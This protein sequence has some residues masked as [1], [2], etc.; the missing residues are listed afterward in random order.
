MLFLALKY[1]YPRLFALMG[2]HRSLYLFLYGRHCWTQPMSSPV[3]KIM[4]GFFSSADIVV[5]LDASEAAI[6][7]PAEMS[8]GN[9]FMIYYLCAFD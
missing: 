4:L 8:T 2:R 3:M 9:R 5:A 1:L 6:M 7:M